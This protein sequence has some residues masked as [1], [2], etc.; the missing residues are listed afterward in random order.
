MFELFVY[1]EQPVDWHLVYVDY[2]IED[3]IKMS[4][5]GGFTTAK[6]NFISILS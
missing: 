2:E 4:I 1:L 5:L 6:V 3:L